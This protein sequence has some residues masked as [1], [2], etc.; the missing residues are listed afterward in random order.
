MPIDTGQSTPGTISWADTATVDNPKWVY[1]VTDTTNYISDTIYGV[2][3]VEI[4]HTID[5]ESHVEGVDATCT[6]GGNIEHW[7]CSV[8]EKYFSDSGGKTEIDADDIE[9]DALGHDMTK[10]EAKS[11]TCLVAG[12]PEYYTCSRC[13]KVFKDADG[14]EEY[15]AEDIE[16][17]KLDH[18]FAEA[19]TTDSSNHWH[20]CT[21][22]CGT[23]D[24]DAAHSFEWKVD[25][26]ATV[27]STGVK[28]EECTVCGY[29]RSE[30]TVID[31][32]TCL[33]P[34]KTHHDRVDPTCVEKGTVEYWSCDD[35]GKN[36]DSSDLELDSLEIAIDPDAHSYNDGVITTAAS[37]TEEGVKTYTCSLCGDTYT[38]SVPK[39]EHTEVEDEAVAATCTT[40]GKTAGKHCSVCGEILEAQ[41]E[42]PA[43]EHSYN[44]GEITAPATCTEEGVKTFTCTA[45]GD[46]YTEDVPANGHTEGEEPTCTTVQTCTVCGEELAAALGH[47]YGWVI[48]KQPTEEE[49]GLKQNICSRCD[50]IDGEEEIAKLVVEEGGSVMDLPTGND[51]DLEISVKESDSLYNIAG[52]SKGYKVEL[53]VVDGEFRTPYDADKTVTLM[54][55]VPEGMDDFKLY[56]R[57]GDILEQVA[58][59]DYKFENNVVTIRTT[60]PEEYVF[61]APLKDAPAAGIPWWVWLIVGI[62]VVAV[63]TL[64]VV[65]VLAVKHKKQGAVAVTADNGEVLGR[66]DKQDEKIDKLIEI[67]DG[68]FNDLV[69]DE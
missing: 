66:L 23:K 20:I 54:L 67:T 33:H 50:D 26:A 10:T 9:I 5:D 32:I 47:D 49:E 27:T 28:H 21:R 1:N 46:T 38:E 8:C 62:S 25:T 6:E 3:E 19:W 18:T 17:A 68:G 2:A 37:C 45:C 31:V 61:N 53:Y 43:T 34:D 11:A 35:C 7:Q 41:T 57:S 22:G 36:L 13:E 63:I 30:N 55:V 12:N 24:G 60:L 64:I 44:D 56:K 39:A 48:T 59:E 15:S 51:Y 40:A 52:V 16:I 65:I 4:K 69:D 42:I 58:E 14:D 29:K